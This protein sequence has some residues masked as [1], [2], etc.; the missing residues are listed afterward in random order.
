MRRIGWRHK[1][2]LGKGYRD[3]KIVDGISAI[4]MVAANQRGDF[5]VIPEFSA[6]E[7]K[8][9]RRLRLLNDV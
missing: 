6:K 3:L 5:I 8:T 7:R 9:E 2:L 4:E 1:N